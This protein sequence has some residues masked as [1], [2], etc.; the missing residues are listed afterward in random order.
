MTLVF[1]VAGLAVATVVLSGSARQLAQL[2]VRAGR[3]LV[4]AAALQVLSA[5]ASPDSAAIRVLIGALTLAVV[6]LFLWANVK[7]AGIPLIALGLAANVLVIVANGAM[8]VSVAAAKRAGISP[9]QL[10]LDADPLREPLTQKTRFKLLIDRVPVVLP[11]YPQ[12][13]SPGDVLVASGV[14]LLLILGARPPRR[15]GDDQAAERD[16]RSTV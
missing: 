9:S 4:V 8:P 1:L 14:A 7:L 6:G 13:V 2:E 11:R 16:T 10:R 3:L 12:L 15:E 5:F